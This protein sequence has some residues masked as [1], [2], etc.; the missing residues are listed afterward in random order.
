MISI[1]AH[2]ENI[3]VLPQSFCLYQNITR[4]FYQIKATSVAPTLEIYIL[5]VNR[6]RVHNVFMLKL[7][8]TYFFF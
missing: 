2:F 4:D 8:C 3:Y 1:Y 5:I 7:A 6:C